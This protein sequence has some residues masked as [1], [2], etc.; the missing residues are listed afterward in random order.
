[1]THHQF[2]SRLLSL[3]FFTLICLAL[4]FWVIK[5]VYRHYIPQKNKATQGL[6]FIEGELA[7]GNTFS[8]LLVS[9]KVPMK[10]TR[11]LIEETGKVFDLRKCRPGDQFKLVYIKKDTSLLHFDYI[12][13]LTEQYRVSSINGN[14]FSERIQIKVDTI[15]TAISGTLKTSLYQS[16]A[17]QGEDPELI[18]K[19]AEMFAWNVDFYVD[20][21]VGD[22]FQILVEKLF[23]GKKQ[24]GYGEIKAARYTG[25]VGKFTVIR[26][27]D[28][29]GKSD[30]FDDE[31]R[32]ISSAFLKSPLKFTRISSRFGMRR[33]PILKKSR[34]HRGIDYTAPTGTPVWAIGPGRITHAGWMGGYGKTIEIRHTNGMQSRYGHLSRIESGVSAG[35]S[36]K[37]K[38]I[39]GAVG[40]TGLSTG[41]HLHFELI[42]NGQ[43]VNP[44]LAKFRTV[45]T[46]VFVKNKAGFNQ[47]K[48]KWSTE[49]EKN[50][51]GS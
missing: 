35:K 9:K 41:P 34:M 7:K 4:F 1:M 5:P 32:S 37:A 39:I 18:E 33:H 8:S 49:L 22:Q 21:R 14:I 2:A 17:D 12:R 42:R 15:M 23:V 26:F 36:V 45:E 28:S 51:K 27:T 10:L 38:E 24:V 44:A 16:I 20:P 40:S 19:V 50:L 13:S 29:D 11:Q 6:I 25:E 48:A 30:Y 3:L 47:V 43:Q 46:P 31:G